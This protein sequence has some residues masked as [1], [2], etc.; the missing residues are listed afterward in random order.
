[1]YVDV[2]LDDIILYALE[3]HVSD[4]HFDPT[5]SGVQIRL[6]QD[7]LLQTHMTVSNEEAELI[8]NR[9]KVCSTLDISEKRLPQDGRW[10]W[11]HKNTSVTMRVS[12]LPSLYGE[13]L[14]CRLMGNE[15]S[16]KDLKALGMRTDIFDHIE[17]LLKRPYGLLLICG[18]TG[19]GKTATLYA[20]LRMLNLD[21]T[22]LICLED[23]VEAEIKGAIQIG[24]NEKIGFT[25][26][27]GTDCV[28]QS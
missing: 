28:A 21:E 9:I 11:S 15:G 12:T 5:K 4:I 25:F 19:S 8:I 7:G 27:K 14:V 3:H 22:K 6:R 10:A 2:T 16:H 18:P 17:Q 23:P 20:M 26:A 13:T 24:I 1:M